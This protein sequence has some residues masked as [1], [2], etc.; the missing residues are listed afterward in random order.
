MEHTI[1][2][3]WLGCGIAFV[4][5]AASCFFVSNDCWQGEGDQELRPGLVER[6]ELTR[7]R[8][9]VVEDLVASR[10]SLFEA[11]ACFREL[12]AESPVDVVHYLRIY[13]P[14]RTDDELHYIHVLMHV[15]A[16]CRGRGVD[17]TIVE[18]LRQEFEARRMCGT[19]AVDSSDAGLPKR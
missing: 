7:A 19:L 6:E 14:D 10:L 2:M 3:L 15:Q 17:A 18:P 13:H 1:R 8:L 9:R 4:G 11:V 5:L 16:N 12:S